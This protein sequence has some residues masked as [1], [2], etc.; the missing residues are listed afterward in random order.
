VFFAPLKRAA[1]DA[2]GTLRLAWWEGNEK[3]KHRPVDVQLAADPTAQGVIMLG[4]RFDVRTGLVLEGT[5]SV[6]TSADEPRPGLYLDCGRELGLGILIGPGG[7]TEFGPM[8]PDGSD[9]RPE[10]HVDR[11]TEFGRTAA[12]R[13]LLKGS[14]LEFYLGDHLVQCWRLPAESSGQIG[15]V[16]PQPQTVDAVKAWH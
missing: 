10:N 11:Q 1:V 13:L 14:L 8:R 3:L 2:D 16:R 6:P 5:V 12:F 15:L 4:H 7:A 9:F